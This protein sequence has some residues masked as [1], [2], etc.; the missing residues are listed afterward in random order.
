[1]RETVPKAVQDCHDLLRWLIP[2]LDEFPR[3]RRFT[4]GERLEGDLLD[5][6][7]RRRKCESGGS[8]QRVMSVPGFLGRGGRGRARTAVR[9]CLA[10]SSVPIS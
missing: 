9:A 2:H 5:V 6:P 8:T 1:M 7:A 4:L 3:A 10:A